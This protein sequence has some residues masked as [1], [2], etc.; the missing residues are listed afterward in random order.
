VF[1]M[2]LEYSKIKQSEGVM[3]SLTGLTNAQFEKLLPAFEH[4]Y[5]NRYSK[6]NLRENYGSVSKP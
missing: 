6:Y 3:R 5:S 4:K 2:G 1:N